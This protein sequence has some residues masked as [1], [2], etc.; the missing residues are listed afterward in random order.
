MTDMQARGLQHPS[1]PNYD[2]LSCA[3]MQ[4]VP[5]NHTQAIECWEGKR[6]GGGGG[7][8]QMNHSIWWPWRLGGYR[9]DEVDVR[10]VTLSVKDRKFHCYRVL[11]ISDLPL[12]WAWVWEPAGEDLD[13]QHSK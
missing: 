4:L 8:E 1:S 13:G 6:G 2:P 9:R 10:L 11:W 3:I 5:T 12:W 7:G